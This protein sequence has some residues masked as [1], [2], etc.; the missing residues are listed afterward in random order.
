MMSC[1]NRCNYCPHNAPHIVVGLIGNPA[2]ISGRLISA[3]DNAHIESV[4]LL[5]EPW[6][7]RKMSIPL[8][9]HLID[10]YM[11]DTQSQQEKNFDALQSMLSKQRKGHQK[12]GRGR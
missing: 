4:A 7:I 1:S 6:P 3:L 11:D 2:W 9:G 12:R 5:D 10:E 8:M